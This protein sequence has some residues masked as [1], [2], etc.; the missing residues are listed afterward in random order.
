MSDLPEVIRP[1]G[2]RA[3][4]QAQMAALEAG[5]ALGSW[6][7]ALTSAPSTKKEGG[8]WGKAGAQRGSENVPFLLHWHPLWGPRGLPCAPRQLLC[9][10]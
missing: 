3:W 7:S 1:V 6:A 5:R 9:F 8:V 4:G 10:S 2:G